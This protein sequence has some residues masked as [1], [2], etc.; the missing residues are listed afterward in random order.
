ML[1]KDRIGGVLLLAFCVGYAILSQRIRLLPFQE[2]AAFTPR[3]MP[4]VLSVLGIGLSLWCIVLPGS[5]EA[6]AMR[7]LDWPRTLAFLG[8]M[9]VYGLS[10]RPAGFLL[11][12]TVFL[13]AGYMLLGERKPHLLLLASVPLVV[14]F[15]ALMHLGL[16][17][18]IAPL[19][20]FLR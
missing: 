18:F 11:A 9:S 2:A 7:G 17:V 16:D 8:L 12:T 6:P 4:E 19:P 14:A 1:T 15:W 5:R 20:A 10:V 13:I 3:T